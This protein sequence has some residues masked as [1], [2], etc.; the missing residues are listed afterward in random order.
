M[1]TGMDW[2]GVMGGLGAGRES[3]LVWLGGEG[4]LDQIR[5]GEGELGQF[6]GVKRNWSGLVG[7]WMGNWSRSGRVA[8]TWA[9]LGGGGRELDQF[10]R[11]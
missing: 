6:R 9:D 7:G 10:R 11:G 8:G 2:R 4:K 1:G 5:K 3:G